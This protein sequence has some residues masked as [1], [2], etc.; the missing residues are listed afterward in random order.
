MMQ[1]AAVIKRARQDGKSETT[2]SDKKPETLSC[3][4]DVKLTALNPF[5]RYLEVQVLRVANISTIN[6][7]ALHS[8]RTK[9]NGSYGEPNSPRPPIDRWTSV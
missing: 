1:C 7:R 5:I 6:D 4:S 8:W 9:Q 3:E 2:R